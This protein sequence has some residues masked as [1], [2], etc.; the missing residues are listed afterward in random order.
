ISV[1]DTLVGGHACTQR[2]KMAFTVVC[3]F[4]QLLP[5]M[6]GCCRPKATIQ[7]GPAHMSDRHAL[8]DYPFH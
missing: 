7:D 8:K 3:A 6:T 4:S 2:P 5:V 1:V